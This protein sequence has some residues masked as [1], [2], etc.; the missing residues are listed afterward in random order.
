MSG[1]G[2]RT[3]RCI[4]ARMCAG[5]I[6]DRL[7]S[8]SEELAK[9]LKDLAIDEIISVNEGVKVVVAKVVHPGVEITI[10]EST[11]AILEECKKATYY[12]SGDEIKIFKIDK[13]SRV[14]FPL[15]L[16]G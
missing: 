14:H 10:G 16:L 5:P 8:R 1:N 2:Q 12:L 9:K 6:S 13:L 15:V 3:E 11:M 4:R 7:L